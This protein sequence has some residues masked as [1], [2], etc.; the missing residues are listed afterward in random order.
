MTIST[1][2]FQVALI[3]VLMIV[4]FVVYVHLN[5]MFCYKTT[6]FAGGAFVFQ[7][8]LGV[9]KEVVQTLVP[10]YAFTFDSDRATFCATGSPALCVYAR[11]SVTHFSFH[12]S[13]EG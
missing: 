1:Q 7:V 13:R 12:E 9:F 6:P 10:A 3:I 4:V 11:Q 8:R 2:G 5:R